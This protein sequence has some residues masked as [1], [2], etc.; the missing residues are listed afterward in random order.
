MSSWS[1]DSDAIQS[2]LSYLAGICA[3]HVEANP[4]IVT[5]VPSTIILVP[6]PVA[7]PASRAP[8]G[9]AVTAGVITPPPAPAS[10]P[11][12]TISL[13][14]PV[15]I[16]I[17]YQ[18]GPL[19]GQPVPSSSTISI[20]ST[21][22]TVPQVKFTTENVE[23]G[24]TGVP[25]ID[26]AAGSP[27]PV[28]ATPTGVAGPTAG[29]SSFATGVL[30]SGYGPTAQPSVKPFPGAANRIGSGIMGAMIVGT[31]GLWLGL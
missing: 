1:A 18:S 17:L 25:E 16:P 23:A 5:S 12:T 15:R 8:A 20:L 24:A 7:T 13:V 11:A 3:P 21:Q 27:A 31:V 30:P 10:I 26:L 6:V 29:L 4:G 2:A 9:S 19:A 14:K 28:Q 22:V